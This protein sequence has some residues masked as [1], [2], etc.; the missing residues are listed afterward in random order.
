MSSNR[1][2]LLQPVATLNQDAATTHTHKMKATDTH[3]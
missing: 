2:R 3:C 1:M